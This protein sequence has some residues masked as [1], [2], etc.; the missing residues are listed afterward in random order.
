MPNT[1]PDSAQVIALVAPFNNEGKILIL[2]RS[3]S[4]HCG[5]LWS[6]PGGKIE[7]GEKPETAAKRELKEE[8]GLTGSNWKCIGTHSHAYSDHLL[9]FFLFTCVCDTATAMETESSY[10]W[11]RECELTDYP[12][13]DAN[14]EL[15]KM[16]K[17]QAGTTV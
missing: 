7:P 12:M 5:G 9:H 2:K 17:T 13:P 11:A 10:I 8:T 3:Q 14:S 1:E 15:I 16:L 6:F 4:Q